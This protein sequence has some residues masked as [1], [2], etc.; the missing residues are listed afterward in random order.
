MCCII[1]S[2]IVCVYTCVL[3]AGTRWYLHWD[4]RTLRAIVAWRTEVVGCGVEQLDACLSH[5]ADHI[6]VALVGSAGGA[7]PSA[8]VALYRYR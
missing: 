6:V 1:V 7:S 2:I 8:E 3:I 5:V 4:V